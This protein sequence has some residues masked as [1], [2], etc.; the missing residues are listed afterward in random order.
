VRTRV[1]SKAHAL[2]HSV[3]GSASS[4]LR[5]N[6]SK[7]FETLSL[8]GPGVAIANPSS[9]QTRAKSSPFALVIRPFLAFAQS[10]LP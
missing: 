3:R 7:S 10:T 6:G 5:H 2:A 9:S 4:A 8:P 1:L